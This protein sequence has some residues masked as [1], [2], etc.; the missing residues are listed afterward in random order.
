MP[1]EFV[2]WVAGSGKEFRVAFGKRLFYF[3]RQAIGNFKQLIRINQD[4]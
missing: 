3:V 2:F 1:K 4:V